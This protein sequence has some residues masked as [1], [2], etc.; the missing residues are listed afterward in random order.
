VNENDAKIS[1]RQNAPSTCQTT[2]PDCRLFANSKFRSADGTCN[3]LRNT[4]WG[5][6]NT[7]LTR[8]ARAAYEDGQNEPRGR[9]S[10]YL[11]N[12]R[13]ISVN[14]HPDAP[15]LNRFVTNMVPQFGQVRDWDPFG[16]S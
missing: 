12:A 2:L 6:I 16:A 11:P 7:P 13:H 14:I 10:S 4:K 15:D 8:V 1:L 3:N 5:S 9:F